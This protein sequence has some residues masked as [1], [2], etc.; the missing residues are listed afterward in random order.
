MMLTFSKK[1]VASILSGQKD[2]TLRKWPKPLVKVGGVY[3]ART[4]RFSKET[5]ARLRVTSMKQIAVSEI[6]D[7]IA[8]R[9][10]YSRADEARSHWLKQG[11]TPEKQLWMIEFEVSK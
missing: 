7:T 5:F 2:V 4:S 9:D 8:K 1:R 3:D 11:F 6:S 10:G